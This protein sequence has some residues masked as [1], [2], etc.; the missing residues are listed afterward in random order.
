MK[1][2][3]YGKIFGAIIK[4][5]TFYALKSGCTLKP[6]PPQCQK[7]FAGVLFA[8]GITVSY[9]QSFS[10]FIKRNKRVKGNWDI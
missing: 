1:S 8:E 2:I 4:P 10:T 6:L 5:D 3:E 9:F 7:V